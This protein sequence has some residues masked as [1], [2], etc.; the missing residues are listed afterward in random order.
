[1]CANF[2]RCQRLCEY[3]AEQSD[4]ALCERTGKE[5]DLRR[6]EGV[7]ENGDDT[8]T[9]NACECRTYH[10]AEEGR[11]V[12]DDGVEGEVVGSVLVG[13]IDVRKRG[14]DRTRGDAENVLGESHHDVEPY[15]IRCNEGVRVIG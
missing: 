14:H 3:E 11:K 2:G 7:T 10:H 12:G 13:Q 9:H 1:M 6:G 8:L 5:Q 4:Y 15:G